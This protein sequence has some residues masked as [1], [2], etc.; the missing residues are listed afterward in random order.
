MNVIKSYSGELVY[1]STLKAVKA[2]YGLTNV[3]SVNKSR[4]EFFNNLLAEFLT[5]CGVDAKYEE[6]FLWI[7]GVP[8]TF[9]FQSSNVYWGVYGP[10]FATALNSGSS[11]ITDIFSGNLYNFK[12]GLVGD[13][14]SAF[15]I[16]VTSYGPGAFQ[17]N[18]VIR[19]IK[20]KNIFNGRQ[21]VLYNSGAN[22]NYKAV[23]IDESGIPVDIGRAGNASITPSPLLATIATDYSDNPGKLP[24]VEM[25][26]GSFKLKDCF[27]FP[28]GSPL[29]A[30]VGITSDNQTV[31]KINGIDYL[32]GSH[33]PSFGIGLI[34]CPTK[35]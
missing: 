31:I 13:P 35:I 9:Y 17:S 29:P 8:F 12:I 24:L 5:E 1:N 28:S 4:T 21:S 20:A 7:E 16:K 11:N 25:V 3:I 27:L 34:K 32:V 26:V 22:I 15:A 30:S 19:I 10:Y 23:D 2:S 6:D 18:T 33:S 14:A